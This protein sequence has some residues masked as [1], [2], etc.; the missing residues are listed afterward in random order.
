MTLLQALESMPD[1]EGAA[2]LREYVRAARETLRARRDDSG[3]VDR[4]MVDEWSAEAREA[5]ALFA[6]REVVCK[7]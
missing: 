6:L 4:L 1:V 7:L 5:A 3:P 2:E